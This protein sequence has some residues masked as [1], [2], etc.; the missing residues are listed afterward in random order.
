MSL[1]DMRAPTA[2]ANSYT[3]AMVSIKYSKLCANSEI[4]IACYIFI[5][6]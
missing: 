6:K 4:I 3:S 1:M 2:S 5:H